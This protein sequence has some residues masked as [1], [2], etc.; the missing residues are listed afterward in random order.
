MKYLYWIIG[1]IVIAGIGYTGY[2]YGISQKTGSGIPEEETSNDTDLDLPYSNQLDNSS[3]PLDGFNIPIS[4]DDTEDE[5]TTNLNLANYKNEAFKFAIDFPKDYYWDASNL[6]WNGNVTDTMWIVYDRDLI[7]FDYQG[8]LPDSAEGAWVDLRIHNVGNQSIEDF[9]KANFEDSDDP[10]KVDITTFKAQNISGK[11]Y[12]YHKS[13]DPNIG[14]GVNYPA[15][16][17]V[18][19]KNSWIYRFYIS[20]NPTDR[21]QIVSSFRT[22]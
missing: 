21:D 13:T 16:F 11:E 15:R 17:V 22:L 18:F 14:P 4:S 20:G 5:P 12:F 19:K 1:I 3:G 6:R 7:D 10:R 2:Y 9:A 8:P